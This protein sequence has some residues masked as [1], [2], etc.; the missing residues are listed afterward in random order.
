[1][2][3]SAGAGVKEA[4]SFLAGSFVPHKEKRHWKSLR[5]NARTKLAVCLSVCV[6][7]NVLIK[8]AKLMFSLPGYDGTN[9]D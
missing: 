5:E 7:E 8:S 6:F 4:E 3:M 9:A 1:M 2:I